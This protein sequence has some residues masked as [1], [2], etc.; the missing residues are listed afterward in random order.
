MLEIY[1]SSNFLIPLDSV[2]FIKKV[3]TVEGELAFIVIIQDGTETDEENGRYVNAPIIS[4]SV[5]E[6]DHF[7]KVYR[8]YISGEKI[9]ITI[10]EEPEEPTPVEVKKEGNLIHFPSPQTDTIQ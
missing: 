9:P 4:N 10:E 5:G 3:C 1:E 8:Y 6:A 2:L 7:L